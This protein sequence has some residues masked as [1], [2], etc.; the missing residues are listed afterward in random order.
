MFSKIEKLVD[1]N[2]KQIVD[3]LDGSVR[4]IVPTISQQIG[5]PLTSKVLQVQDSLQEHRKSIDFSLSNLSSMINTTGVACQAMNCRL[6]E[7]LGAV[8]DIQKGVSQPGEGLTENSQLV[9][10]EKELSLVVKATNDSVI[11]ALVSRPECDS[12]KCVQA[13]Q[14]LDATV[15]LL[16]R[17]V[18][19]KGKAAES[20]GPVARAIEAT[21]AKVT[22]R[23][24]AVIAVKEDECLSLAGIKQAISEAVEAAM[25]SYMKKID[26]TMA[27]MSAANGED[28]MARSVNLA[29][30]VNQEELERRIEEASEGQRHD[31]QKLNERF[32]AMMS[33]NRAE[34]ARLRAEVAELQNALKAAQSNGDGRPGGGPVPDVGG[35]EELEQISAEEQKQLTNAIAKSDWPTFSGKGEYDHMD[36]IH[37][38]DSAQRHSRVSDGVIVLKLLTILTDGARSWFKTME[39]VHKNRKWSFWR[40]ELCKKYGTASWKR[41]KEDAFDADK[42]VAGVTVPSD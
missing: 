41:K 22:A 13:I 14:A 1:G 35:E 4:S 21:M 30:S 25:G 11:A 17:A 6:G 3:Q 5:K 12:E 37:W 32:D 33:Q 36:F 39:A 34:G 31:F 7:I 9:K 2:S 27:K 24:D 18:D 15:H 10:L 40:A 23:L 28:D 38:I 29:R 42:F 16:Q 20:G 8:R 26:S 19:L